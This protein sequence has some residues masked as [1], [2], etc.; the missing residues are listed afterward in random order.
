MRDVVGFEGLYSVTKDGRVW[1]HDKA[2]PVGVNGGIDNRNARWLKPSN[3]KGYA[4]VHLAING[5]KYARFVHRLVAD[6]FLQNP[7]L[8]AFVNHIDGNK[9]NNSVENLEWCTAKENSEH[10]YKIGLHTTSRSFG[11][12]NGQAFLDV[13]TVKAMRQLFKEVGN[14]AE[15]ARRFGLKPKHAYDICHYKR[16]AHVA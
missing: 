7:K 13:A 12:S 11:E 14:T 10:A 5:K 2:V 9:A 6:A 16:W 4:R 8:L 15:V 1:R 3:L